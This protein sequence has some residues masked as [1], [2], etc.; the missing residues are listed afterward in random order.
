MGLWG[1][2]GEPKTKSRAY[3]SVVGKASGDRLICERV[4]CLFGKME[5]SGICVEEE[6]SLRGRVCK[7]RR[8]TGKERTK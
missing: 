8:P 2:K 6:D 5:D 7:K 1:G 4:C 3:L